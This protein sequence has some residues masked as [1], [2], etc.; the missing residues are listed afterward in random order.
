MK[1]TDKERI[2]RTLK[3]SQKQEANNVRKVAGRKD[4]SPGTY[5]K[6]LL[7]LLQYDDDAIYNIDEDEDVLELIL[8][9]KDDLPAAKWDVVVKKAVKGTKVRE[10]DSAITGL[11][12][13]LTD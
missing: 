5:A 8:E 13:L 10:K 7:A 3:R 12:A 2:E 1:R 11:M 4:V 6:E 9:M